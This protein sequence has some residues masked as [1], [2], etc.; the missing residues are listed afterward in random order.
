MLH[1]SQPSTLD[2]RSHFH[3]TSYFDSDTNPS[4]EYVPSLSLSHTSALLSVNT[5]TTFTTSPFQAD[6]KHIA[7]VIEKEWETVWEVFL[8]LSTNPGE[9]ATN[10]PFSPS[11]TQAIISSTTQVCTTTTTTP[12]SS[13]TQPQNSGHLH[14]TN[15]PISNNSKKS[16]KSKKSKNPPQITIPKGHSPTN[17]FP[18]TDFRLK[19][20]KKF[21]LPFQHHKAILQLDHNTSPK[22]SSTSTTTTTKPPPLNS[23]ITQKIQSASTNTASSIT[24]ATTTANTTTTTTNHTVSTSYTSTNAYATTTTTNTRTQTKTPIPALMQ[25]NIPIPSRIHT[26]STSI[27]IPLSSSIAPSSIAPSPIFPRTLQDLQ[28]LG[29]WGALMPSKQQTKEVPITWRFKD[30]PHPRNGQRSTLHTQKNFCSK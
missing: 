8:E 24:V 6:Q 11:T 1:T 30:S 29:L 3:T 22:S 9:A 18:A 28:R 25:L 27:T 23:E 7:A 4:F 13:H 14:H 10:Q 26:P 2:N 20:L 17:M 19:R 15:I 12:S 21:P 5:S 16:K